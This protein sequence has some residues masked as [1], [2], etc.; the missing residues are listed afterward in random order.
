ME[1][2]GGNHDDWTLLRSIVNMVKKNTINNVF[3]PPAYLQFNQI[4]D[5]LSQNV[6]NDIEFSLIE[7][8][9]TQSNESD[10]FIRIDSRKYN[11]SI[12]LDPV[13]IRKRPEILQIVIEGINRSHM[14]SIPE[15]NGRILTLV[16]N[17]T[18]YI[19]SLWND[20]SK[21]GNKP[22]LDLPAVLI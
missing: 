16:Q 13:W 4:Y 21:L 6:L 11:L 2:H 20:F 9:Y 17:L 3:A 12:S 10:Y 19:I 14:A 5:V 1:Q 18:D 8:L 22:L 15:L 7:L